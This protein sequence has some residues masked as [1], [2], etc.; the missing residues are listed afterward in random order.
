MFDGVETKAVDAGLFFHPD[1]PIA[2]AVAHVV[3][4]L[5]RVET[6]VA[7]EAARLL[8]IADVRAEEAGGDVVAFGVV[9]WVGMEVLPVFREAS[10]ASRIV[11]EGLGGAGSGEGNVTEVFPFVRRG[12]GIFAAGAG[13]A[14]RTI[15]VV[16]DDVLND[17]DAVGVKDGDGAE[18]LVFDAD[19]S[20]GA[21]ALELVA[22]VVVVEGGI[23]NG[24]GG[25]FVFDGGGNPYGVDAE[26]A[27]ARGKVS[28]VSGPIVWVIVVPV[29]PPEAL[30]DDFA[31]GG[32]KGSAGERQTQQE[33]CEEPAV[34]CW[35]SVVRRC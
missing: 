24:A 3:D 29:I 1:E 25:V 9:V 34:H 4:L 35:T 31:F 20:G 33:Q 28:E 13:V 6:H 17:F 16:E 11:G 7:A 18:E 30:K 26:F 5:G 27:K 22:E 32:V 2:H 14:A 12:G 23:A 8:V 19:A 10:A 15:H 21:V